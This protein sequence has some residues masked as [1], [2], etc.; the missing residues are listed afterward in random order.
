MRKFLLVLAC[1]C[2]LAG[3][4]HSMFGMPTVSAQ[5]DGGDAEA[6]EEVECPDTASYYVGI[7]NAYYDTGNFAY[8]IEAYNCALENDPDFVQ[9]YVDRGFAYA[10]QFNF[11]A[12]I[13]DYERALALDETMVEAYNN[14]GLAYAEQGNFGLA[15]ADFD[16][17]I[18]LAPEFA[19]GYQNRAVIHA[20]EGNLDL[21]MA[22][23]QAAIDADP[24]YADAHAG[25]AAIYSALAAIQYEEFFEVS[26]SRRTPLPAGSPASVINDIVASRE[27][28]T[29]DVWLRLLDPSR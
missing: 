19:Q 9:G 23:F 20:A 11:E 8:A 24:T 15:I 16:L 3:G 29:N 14:R 12:A 13:E 7:G 2:I 1:V 26:G 22:D 25:L 18:G 17:V 10:A 21:A 4:A 28:G 27:N 5:D 6:T